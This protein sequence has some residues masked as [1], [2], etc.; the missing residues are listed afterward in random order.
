[1]WG[2]FAAL[3]GNVGEYQ[4]LFSAIEQVS[5]RGGVPLPLSFTA[6]VPSATI[7]TASSLGHIFFQEPGSILFLFMT[8]AAIIAVAAFL[9]WLAMISVAAL[10]RN[11]ALVAASKPLTSSATTL[12]ASRTTFAPLLVTFL[13]GKI[14]VWMLL[15]LVALFAALAILDPYFGM[16]SFAVAFLLLIPTAIA[17]SFIVRYMVS[18]IVLKKCSLV[19]ALERS[20]VLL[21]A[22]WLVTLE[23]AALLGVV[24]VLVGALVLFIAW[25]FI[26]PTFIAAAVLWQLGFGAWGTIVGLIALVVLIVL[27]FFFA[28]WLATFQ[29]TAWTMLYVRLTQRTKTVSKIVRVLSRFLPDRRFRLFRRA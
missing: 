13:F 9:I 8:G 17:L 19:D 15:A 7:Q 21:K 2:L 29:W 16:P 6:D 4:V 3:I 24:S 14:V 10:V 22:H 23:M 11:A 28:A 26:V 27:L 1:M 12:A 25:L 20:I 5:N 18:F